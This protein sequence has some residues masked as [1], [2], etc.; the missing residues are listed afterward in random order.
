MK[1]VFCFTLVVTLLILPVSSFGDMNPNADIE[2]LHK[3]T[4]F[5]AL[6]KRGEALSKQAQAG[7]L[8]K[9][10]YSAT[11]MSL[12]QKFSPPSLLSEANISAKAVQGTTTVNDLDT[13]YPPGTVLEI[14][15][16]LTVA[17]GSYHAIF[18]NMG[19]VAMALKA[20]NG[21]N[22]KAKAR[23]SVD[24]QGKLP[25]EVTAD[26]AENM[27]MTLKVKAVGGSAR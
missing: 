22:A 24:S 13:G 3:Q 11:G 21:S 8:G 16:H 18:K 7:Q 2:T 4:D 10:T 12:N 5:D 19:R 23:V 25:Y 1:T 27:T 17:K 14:E 26:R 15:G 9:M 6:R 20:N